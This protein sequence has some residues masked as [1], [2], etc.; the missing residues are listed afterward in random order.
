MGQ[1]T[2]EEIAAGAQ[3]SRVESRITCGARTRL[4]GDE[5]L[6]EPQPPD[7]HMGK[8][9]QKIGRVVKYT[10]ALPRAQRLNRFA[11]RPNDRLC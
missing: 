11:D 6:L 1:L 10:C 7:N 4:V 5:A 8:R 2:L 3:F 9:P